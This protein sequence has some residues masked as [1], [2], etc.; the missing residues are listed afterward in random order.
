[1]S[2]KNLGLAF[3][4]L[5]GVVGPAILG[6]LAFL[7][8]DLIDVVRFLGAAILVLGMTILLVLL[9]VA[10]RQ[11]KLD[12]ATRRQLSAFS[13]SES[14]HDYR[15]KVQV[16]QVQSIVTRL[17]FLI[18]G[19][20][21]HHAA[22]DDQLELPFDPESDLPRVLFVTS[23]GAGMGHLTRCLAV[24]RS[25]EEKFQAHF[26]SLS[27]S[28]EI[29]RTF[30]FEVLKFKSQKAS[31]QDTEAWNDNFATFFD[32]V[33]RVNRPHAI[34]FDGTWIYR[35]VHESSKRHGAS[36]VW[37]RRGLWKDTSDVTQLKAAHHLVDH[38]L[39]PMDVADGA[40]AGP[41][42]GLAGAIVP[43]PTVTKSSEL[44]D[45]D[46][47][48]AELG[49]DTKT[50]YVLVQ[51]GA[52][53][54]ND[55]ADWREQAISRLLALSPSYDVVLGLSPLSNEYVDD[56]PGVH[57]LRKYPLARYLAAF[58][59]QVIAAGYNSIHESI[60]FCTPAVVVPNLQTIT[61]NQS[62]RAAEYERLGFGLAA[63]TL[64]ELANAIETMSTPDLR[65][66]FMTALQAATLPSD[67]GQGA[68]S[69]IHDW[70]THDQATI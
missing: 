21:G 41:V 37:L 17:R 45:R 14:Q 8:E 59:F 70:I 56:R 63:N 10:Y 26:V 20:S 50:R 12:K 2:P 38:V 42:S 44:L 51:L 33:C 19:I 16:A 65:A 43:A 68:A 3:L 58:D 66:V 55:V 35:G 23:N 27:S 34:V 29:V 22:F 36:L 30:G 40:D 28:A 4:V 53:A 25:G 7:T 15:R 46:A 18:E 1:M 64:D 13:K 67:S 49:L 39:V 52:G 54:I 5:G 11:L 31:L 32:G 61:D 69:K 6:L 57:V 24:A 48:L 60:R 9:V 47:A 62:L